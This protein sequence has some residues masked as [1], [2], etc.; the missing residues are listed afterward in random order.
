MEGD[1]VEATPTLVRAG[2]PST[3]S[4]TLT[5]RPLATLHKKVSRRTGVRMVKQEEDDSLPPAVLLPVSL[6]PLHQL[7]H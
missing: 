7:F 5:V 1:Q 2:S 3:S 4:P 6:R